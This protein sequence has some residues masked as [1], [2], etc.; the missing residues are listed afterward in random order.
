VDRRGRVRG[1]GHPGGIE[2]VAD[3]AQGVCAGHA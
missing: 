2:E 1:G 3:V